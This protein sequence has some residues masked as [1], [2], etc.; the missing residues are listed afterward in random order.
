M[1]TH[2]R[3]SENAEMRDLP[4]DRILSSDGRSGLYAFPP[5]GYRLAEDEPWEGPRDGTQIRFMAEEGVVVPLWGDDGLIFGD[6]EE[7]I[8]EWGISEA[9]ADAL[10][11]WGQASQAGD[12]AELDA[13]AARLI[14]A[15]NKELGYRFPIVYKP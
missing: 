13:E 11:A 2:S 15:L 1:A 12:S 5:E 10:V 6:G 7:L 3:V 8:R 14:R 9:L 4:P